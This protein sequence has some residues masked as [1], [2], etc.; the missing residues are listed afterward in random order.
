MLAAAALLLLRAGLLLLL[1]PRCSRLPA[2]APFWALVAAPSLPD[3][4]SSPRPFA[5]LPLASLERPGEVLDPLSVALVLLALLLP[6]LSKVRLPSFPL[7]SC[8][9]SSFFPLRPFSGLASSLD[10]LDAPPRLSS[11]SPRPACL[12]REEWSRERSRERSLLLL[13]LLLATLLQSRPP[14]S[15]PVPL[16]P[17]DPLRLLLLGLREGLRLF[18]LR[19][20]LFFLSRLRLALRLVRLLRRSGLR[21]ELGPLLLILRSLLLFRLPPLPPLLEPL[22][23]CEC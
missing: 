15:E 3:P 19:L 21:L 7:L 5:P 20:P 9:L 13:L 18:S 17:P 22:R 14:R 4:A 16:P 10:F 6:P 8:F 11:P 1:S 23:L 12:L 2:A